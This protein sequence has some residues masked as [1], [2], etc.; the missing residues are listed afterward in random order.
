M[1]NLRDLKRWERCAKDYA[2]KC[3]HKESKQSVSVLSYGVTKTNKGYCSNGKRKNVFIRMASKCLTPNK[4]ELDNAMWQMGS[5]F[6]GIAHLHND[7]STKI[8][9]MCW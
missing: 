2:S 7:S 8:P 5:D 6:K 3:L 9:L 4:E 1:I